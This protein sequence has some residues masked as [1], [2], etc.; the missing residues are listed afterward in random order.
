M[1]LMFIDMIFWGSHRAWS[2]VASMLSWVKGEYEVGSRL[3]Q[4]I[5]SIS[6]GPAPATRVWRLVEKHRKWIQKMYKT[7]AI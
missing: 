2:I 4:T 6:F 7:S 5:L 3:E 1:F